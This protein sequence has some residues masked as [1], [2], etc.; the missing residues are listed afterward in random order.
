MPQNRNHG[1]HRPGDCRQEGSLPPLPRAHAFF[2]P[3]KNRGNKE[4]REYP[5][6]VVFPTRGDEELLTLERE[7]QILQPLMGRLIDQIW[8]AFGEVSMM[9]FPSWPRNSGGGFLFQ[10]ER[11]E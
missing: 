4:N 5:V 3:G 6:V 1:D 8:I 2:R 11:D 10:V 7:I 9:T